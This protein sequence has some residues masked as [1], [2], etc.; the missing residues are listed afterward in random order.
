[1]KRTSTLALVAAALAMTAGLAHPMALEITSGNTTLIFGGVDAEGGI[2]D[3]YLSNGVVE[4]IIDDVGDRPDLVG[5]VPPGDEPPIQSEINADRRLASRPRP[6]RGEQR[7]PHPDVHRRR[8]QHV[9]LHLLRHDQRPEHRHDPGHREPRAPA[10]LRP[11]EPLHGH[12]DRLHGGRNRPL[13]HGHDARPRTTAPAPATFG[14]FLDAFI[15]TQRSI[16]PF[17]AG[18]TTIGGRGFNHPVLNLAS[19]AASIELPDLHG[20]PR[21]QPSRG[22]DHGPGERDDRGPGQLRPRR[23]ADREGR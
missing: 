19:P 3:W 20:R 13:H 17:S 7:Q 16:V 2:G 5:V 1:M 9:E 10:A 4:A 18:A 6:R 8:A 22:R 21:E 23:H 11:A 14:G 12:R 15:W